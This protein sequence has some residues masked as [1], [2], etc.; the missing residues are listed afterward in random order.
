MQSC[1]VRVMQYILKLTMFSSERRA[2]Y[3]KILTQVYDATY[4][5][6][7][8]WAYN[9]STSNRFIIR[10]EYLSIIIPL[11]SDK[12]H[13]HKCSIITLSCYKKISASITASINLPPQVLHSH[14]TF[15]NSSDRITLV[16]PHL[17]P[18][19]CTSVRAVVLHVG[20]ISQ[21]CILKR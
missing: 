5:W 11:S 8:V 14:I 10:F 20:L 17:L 7:L 21:F 12:F 3:S 1:H 19:S 4:L 6:T 9:F 18:H 16:F 15:S 2:F 13:L